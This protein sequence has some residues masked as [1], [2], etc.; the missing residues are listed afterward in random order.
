M[1]ARGRIYPHTDSLHGRLGALR[2]SMLA[3]SHARAHD[4]H[5]IG[6]IDALLFAI[7]GIVRHICIHAKNV[8]VVVGV[9]VVVI[10]SLVRVRVRRQVRWRTHEA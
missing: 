9:P 3:P 6:P 10:V 2:A 7:V 1:R 5:A 8:G 4:V